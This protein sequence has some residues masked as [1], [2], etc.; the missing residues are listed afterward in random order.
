[1]VYVDGIKIYSRIKTEL[2]HGC[3]WC[4]MWADTP[5]ELISFAQKIGLN[6]SWLQEGRLNHFDLVPSFRA[7]A[8]KNGAVPKSLKEWLKE[9]A[10]NSI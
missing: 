4:H 8:I 3:R 7:K 6:S 5:E 10:I 9:K 1:M 2:K